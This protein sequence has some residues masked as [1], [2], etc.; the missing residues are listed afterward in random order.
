YSS[1]EEAVETRNA[2]YNLQWPTNGG[3]ATKPPPTTTKP[4][5]VY[6][7]PPPAYTKPPPA[8][9][10][11][12]QQMQLP[13]PPPLPLPPPPPLYRPPQLQEAAVALPP[14]PPLPEKMEPPVVTLDDLF[15]KTKATPRI[16]Y[17]PLSDEQVAAKL[18]MNAKQSAGRKEVLEQ[19]R[20]SSFCVRFRSSGELPICLKPKCLNSIKT[21]IC[22]LLLASSSKTLINACFSFE[23]SHSSCI[24][25]LPNLNPNPSS[26]DTLRW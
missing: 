16:Y 14:P 11:P 24:A 2:V 23:K 22:F 17:L 18:K 15:R 6:T 7:K 26:L 4:H 9:T 19:R 12:P 1:I 5:P 21:R 25:N 13:P 20:K 8:A 10:K 3:P